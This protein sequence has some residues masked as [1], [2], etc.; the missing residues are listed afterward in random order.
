MPVPI[1][2]AVL[3]LTTLD[4]LKFYGE[5]ASIELLQSKSVQAELKVTESQRAKFNVRADTFNAVSQAAQKSAAAGE[6]D[7]AEFGKR[8]GEAQEQ[9]KSAVLLVLSTA[10]VTRLGQIT[11]Q[12]LSYTA[13]FNASLAARLAITKAQDAALKDGWQSLGK[14]VAEVERKARE[15][16][17]AKFQKLDP[18]TDE[19]KA[20]AKADFESEMTAANE[21][22]QPELLALRKTF[23]DLVKKT[24]TDGQMKTWN[25]L[26][27]PAFKPAS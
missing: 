5:L 27:G 25:D 17:I 13:V 22:V 11:L 20:R 4:E 21:K 6:I 26:K 14:K 1:A 23:E 18:K 15:P 2:L 7:K 19:E 24:L 16:I 12:R 9:L 10:Q 3:A 8:I